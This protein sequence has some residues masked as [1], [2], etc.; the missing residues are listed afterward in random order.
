M[1]DQNFSF[2]QISDQIGTEYE[3]VRAIANAY[4]NENR[5]TICTKRKRK[6]R[7]SSDKEEEEALA[8]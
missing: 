6:K 1:V 5:R 4:I 8:V 2:K 3:N 7:N